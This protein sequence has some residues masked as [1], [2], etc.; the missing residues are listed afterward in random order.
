MVSYGP[1]RLALGA[2]A[3][4]LALIAKRQCFQP[5][6]SFARQVGGDLVRSLLQRILG[7]GILGNGVGSP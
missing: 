6:F 1:M 2:S 5:R 7:N 3:A 4:L